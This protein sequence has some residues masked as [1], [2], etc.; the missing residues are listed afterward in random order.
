LKLTEKREFQ[1]DYKNMKEITK[2]ELVPWPSA[3]PAENFTFTCTA[4]GGLF[5]F[6]FK[7]FNDRWNLWVT[8]PDGTVRQAGTEQGVTSWTGCQD[9]GL[10]IEGE[11]QKIAFDELY[12]TEMFILTWL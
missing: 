9:W 6:H 5:E 12:H 7:W 1:N 11:M 4:E 3:E 10:V 2:K 8:L